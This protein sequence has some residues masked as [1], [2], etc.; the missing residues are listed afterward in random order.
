MSKYFDSTSRI[1]SLAVPDEILKAALS[2]EAVDA[3]PR[4]SV[5]AKVAL[6]SAAP[7]DR[8][9]AVSGSDLQETNLTARRT[10]Q[11]PLGKIARV[12]F[13]DTNSLEPAEESYRALRTRL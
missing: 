1:A 10:I 4:D 13:Q 2:G 5:P 7:A 6:S 3:V 12:Q 9:E 8:T 11:L